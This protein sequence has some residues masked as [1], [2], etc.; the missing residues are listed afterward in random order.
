MTDLIT[1]SDFKNSL[2]SGMDKRGVPA[3]VLQD[4]NDMI[5]NGYEGEIFRENLL[6]H[7][8]ILKEGKFSLQQY[9][10]SVKYMSY[11]LIG[12]TNK[13]SYCLTFPDKY[14]DWVA[15]GVSE[16]DISAYVAAYNKSKLVMRLYDITLVPFHLLNQPYRQAALLKEVSLMRGISTSGKDVSDMVQHLAAAKVLDILTPPESIQTELQMK[17]KESEETGDLKKA[18]AD[19]AAAQKSMIERGGDL[20]DVAESSIV[21]ADFEE[22]ED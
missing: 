9:V 13:A 5:A 7:T 22:I 4:V 3:Q 11:K 2:P 6:S 10:N 18:L 21:T 20:R 14:T 12:K 8:D 1:E 15:N 19:L 16:K 17:R